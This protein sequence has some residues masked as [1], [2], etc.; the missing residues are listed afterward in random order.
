MDGDLE[1]SILNSDL[2]DRRQLI[3]RRVKGEYLRFWHVH[4]PHFT[5]HGEN[6]CKTIKM[7]LEEILSPE[8][9]SS[10]NEYEVFMLLN[11]VWLHDIGLMRKKTLGETDQEIRDK[12]H[13]RSKE[14]IRRYFKGLLSSQEDI[15]ISEIA[16]GHSK[17][18]DI[19]TL[20]PTKSIR[21][22]EIG[23][24]EIRLQ[25]LAALLRFFD[26]LDICHTRTSEA[27]IDVSHLSDKSKFYHAI[28]SRVSGLIREE[29]KILID[30]NYSDENEKS[31]L[32]KSI[33]MP[34]NIELGS[35]RKIFTENGFYITNIEPRYYNVEGLDPLPNPPDTES[36]VAFPESLPLKRLRDEEQFYIHLRNE[37]IEDAQKLIDVLVE[38]Y[39]DDA[40][41]WANYS[42]FYTRVEIY[43]ERKVL[44][45][46]QNALNIEPDNPRYLTYIGHIMGE[47]LHDVDQSF[48]YLKKAYLLEP[49]NELSKLNYVEALITKERFEDANNLAREI[50]QESSDLHHICLSKFF[51]FCSSCLIDNSLED[52][53]DESGFLFSIFQETNERG[54][55]WI[56]NKLLNFLLVS[57]DIDLRVIKFLTE[58]IAYFD[59]NITLEELLKIRDEIF[60]TG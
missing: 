58:I 18:A 30:I 21:H 10:F 59:E 34:L 56:F 24:K 2:Q 39:P 14:M 40:I 35:V 1:N 19:T 20:D 13:I 7:T 50:L 45:G 51:S 38:E 12:H 8:I 23:T 11:G 16:W 29:T 44:I 4:A 15:I 32:S 36:E 17:Q 46:I 41:I 31:I 25:F 26:A 55:D 6:H 42:E 60:N 5:D 57:K 48:E 22:F 53:R 49:E 9:I 52:K 54:Q 3:E 33:V 43:D 47:Y 27:V 37:D 28:H